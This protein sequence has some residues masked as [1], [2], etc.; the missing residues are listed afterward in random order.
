MPGT[1]SDVS[2]TLVASTIRRRRCAVV[3]HLLLFGG[4]QPGVERQHLGV[5]IADGAAQRFGGVADLALAGQ[6]HQHVAGRF[7]LE[8][9]DGVDDRLGLVAHLG[10]D[11]LVV[12]V[13]GIVVVVRSVGAD[14]FQWAVTDLDRVG[15]PGHLDDRRAVEVRGEALRARWSPR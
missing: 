14:D 1:V 5:L 9:V 3:E 12:G 6:E 13:V 2:A 11:D 7:G 15:A 8:F 10:A 4:R